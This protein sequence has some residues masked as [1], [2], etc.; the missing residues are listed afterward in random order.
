MR[1]SR[2]VSTRSLRLSIAAVAAGAI[3]VAGSG[4]A[5]SAP[6]QAPSGPGGDKV[7]DNQGNGRG[8][9]NGN[10]RGNGNGNGRG[11]GGEGRG[12]G[13]EG[14][15]NPNPIITP[16][17]PPA[18]PVAP[19]VSR[20]PS[21]GQSSPGGGNSSGGGSSGGSAPR[22]PSP[23]TGGGSGGGSGGGTSTSGGS[24]AGGSSSGGSGASSGGSGR[25][26][27]PAPT[28]PRGLPVKGLSAGS[29]PVSVAIYMDL[30]DASDAATYLSVTTGLLSR[31]ASDNSATITFNPIIA[32]RDANNMEAALAVLAGANQNR[33]WCVTAQVA[34]LRSTRGGDWINRT[35]LRSVARSCGLSSSRFIRDA[36]GNKLY[37]RLNDIRAQA[38]GDGVGTTPSYVVKGSGGSQVVVNPGSADAV[39]SAIAGRN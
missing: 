12:N 13:G 6:G 18:T 33:T 22:S 9:G 14:E 20:P 17:A 34:T 35:A 8:N 39:L 29:G 3:L 27:M 16:P 31:I 11:N 5:L 19:P 15:T 25:G 37:P 24:G 23:L 2:P 7:S 38:R 30:G 26:A 28:V 36:T 10:G 4:A 21:G 32:G 1:H